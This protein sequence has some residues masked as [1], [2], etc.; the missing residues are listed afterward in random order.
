MAKLFAFVL[1]ALVAIFMLQISVMASEGSY[2]QLKKSQFG[3]GSLKSSLNAPLSARGDAGGPNTISRAC[4]SVKSV[5]QSAIACRRGIM[6]I[7]LFAPATT[8]G[9]L[10]KVDQNALDPIKIVFF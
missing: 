4:S 3:A 10:K 8:I 2:N 5:A 1:V 6:V 9:R 7:K